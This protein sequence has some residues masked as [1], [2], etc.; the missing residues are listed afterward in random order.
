MAASQNATKRVAVLD[1]Y[2]GIAPKHFENIKHAKVSYWDQT[3]DASKEDELQA[4]IR[5]L[6]P[7]EVVSSMRERTAFPPGLLERLP[8]LKLL[9]TTGMRNNSID[10]PAASQNNIIVTGTKGERLSESHYADKP[11]EAP[12]PATGPSTVIQHSWALLLSLTSRIVEHHSLLQDQSRPTAWQQGTILTL[13]GK[14]LG[15]VGL[16]KLGRAFGKIAVQS[17]GM[18]IVAWS[19]N[20]TQEKADEQAE[21]AGLER[22]TFQVVSKQD[23]LQNADVVSLHLVLSDRTRGVVGKDELG[24]MNKRAVLLNTSRGGLIDEAALI[25]SL[26]SGGIAGFA[27]DVFWEEPLGPQSAWRKVGEWSKSAVVLSPHMAYVNEGTMNRWYEEH[28]EILQQY[29]DG[30]ELKNRLN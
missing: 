29:L 18:K 23:L 9:L 3:L 10:L 14:T 20:L 13:P 4:L 19:S 5:R 22:G 30:K 16:G 15:L 24:L 28:A 2:A 8:K 7:Y 27:S 21:A 17:F 1:D 12:P 25:E 6:E 11:Y 26:K